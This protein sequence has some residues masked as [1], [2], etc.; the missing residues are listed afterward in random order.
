[1]VDNIDDDEIPEELDLA[2]I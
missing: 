2:K 1:M